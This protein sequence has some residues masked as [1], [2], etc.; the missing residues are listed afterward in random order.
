VP[1]KGQDQKPIGLPRHG[2]REVIVD[3][4]IEFVQNRQAQRGG[5]F[6]LEL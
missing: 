2:D 5:E 6:D 4:L 1:S 3:A